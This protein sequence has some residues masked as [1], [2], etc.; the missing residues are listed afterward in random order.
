MSG[1][2]QDYKGSVCEIKTM[3][4]ALLTMGSIAEI[5]EE[6]DF[7]KV[8]NDEEELMV[9]SYDTLV[10]VSVYNAKLGFKVLVGRVFL[11]TP[12]FVKI[13]Q[14]TSLVDYERRAF[15]RVPVDIPAKIYHLEVED[16]NKM[17]GELIEETRIKDMSLS[18]MFI[19][20]NFPYGVQKRYMVCFDLTGNVTINL[21][22][23]V[24]RHEQNEV[25]SGYGLLFEDMSERQGDTIYKY[26]FKRQSEI[27]RKNRAL[28]L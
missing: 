4:N 27:I 9:I 26:I 6:M 1:L 18:G 12:K 2:E 8:E 7:I 20:S 24:A 25:K 14:V 22:C 23:K 16:G 15:F 17:C 13:V 28:N 5:D 11:S 19:R 21:I 10:K 3:S